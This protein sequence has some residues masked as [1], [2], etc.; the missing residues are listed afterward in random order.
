VDRNPVKP[1]FTPRPIIKGYGGH[2][3]PPNFLKTTHHLKQLTIYA[4]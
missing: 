2:L 1:Q 4:K 3:I